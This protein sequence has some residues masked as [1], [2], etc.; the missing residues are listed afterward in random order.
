[1]H[2][3]HGSKLNKICSWKDYKAVCADLRKIYRAATEAEA[4]AALDDFAAKWDGKYPL[5]AKS[6]RKPTGKIWMNFSLILILSARRY[7]LPTRLSLWIRVWKKGY[8]KAFGFFERWCDLQS[9]IFSWYEFS[10][11]WSMPIREWG[12]ALNQFA[13]YF[14]N[15]VPLWFKVVY[16]KN[17]TVSLSERSFILLKWKMLN[18]IHFHF[19][20]MLRISIYCRHTYIV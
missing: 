19:V 9:F 1:M 10:K 2:R 15:R 8:A 17:L 18:L 13:I 16:T 4:L 7:T 3:A 6:W 11:R 5:I 12:A 14:G 20:W